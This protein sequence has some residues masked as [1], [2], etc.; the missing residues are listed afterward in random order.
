[1]F[2]ANA[3]LDQFSP[4]NLAFVEPALILISLDD[5]ARYRCYGL[6][7]IPASTGLNIGL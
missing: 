1:M 6:D 7:C 4:I 2:M 5:L 3:S